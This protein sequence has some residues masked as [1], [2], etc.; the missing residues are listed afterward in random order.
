MTILHERKNRIGILRV[1]SLVCLVILLSMIGFSFANGTQQA[2]ADSNIIYVKHNASGANDGTSWADAYTSLQSAIGTAN[3]GDEIWVAQGVYKPTTGTSRQATFSLPMDVYIFGGF[4]GIETAR[5]QRDWL[6]NVTVLSGD[7]TGD[8]ITDA[9]GIIRD[10]ANILGDDNVFHVVTA[11][12]TT[13]VLDGFVVTGG[14][15]NGGEDHDHGAGLYVQSAPEENLRLSPLLRNLIV[16]GNLAA[17][18]G[19]GMYNRESNPQ[20]YNV[21]FQ[22]NV[23]AAN[24]GGMYASYSQAVLTNVD[25]RGNQA[26]QGGG[27]YNANGNPMLTNV[28]LSGNLASSSG[29][30]LFNSFGSPTLNGVTF[31]SN[32]APGSGGGIYSTGTSSSVTVVNS[33]LWD[34]TS[35]YGPEI[36]RRSGAISVSYSIVR[37][38]YAGEGNVDAD[39]LFVAPYSSYEAPTASGDYRLRYGSPAIDAGTNTD[40]PATDLD[41]LP[42]PNDGDASGT[43]TCDMGA[44]EAGT[45]VCSVGLGVHTFTNHPGVTIEVATL[46]DELGCLYVDEMGAN[47]AHATGAPGNG[48][49][50]GRYWLI[51]GLQSDK[52]TDATGFEVNLTLPHNLADH[53]KASVCRYTGST[54]DCAQTGSTTTTVWR[55]GISA[56]SDWTVGNDVPT[57]V[58]LASFTATPQ[59][60]A[61]LVTW[62]T[63]SEL[64]N[65]GFNLYRSTSPAGPWTQLNTTLIPAQNP[66]AVFGAT[67]EW[68]DTDVTPGEAVYYRLEDVDVS[69]VSTFH[70]PVSATASGVTTVRVTAFGAATNQSSLLTLTLMLTGALAITFSIWNGRRSSKLR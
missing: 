67:Y 8:D 51:R 59:N 33:I 17:G 27:I 25:F 34:N 37:S 15:A 11:I 31:G 48:T 23:A 28:A 3:W 6:T 29:G 21:T 36:E 69:G 63:A 18:N 22:S 64:D 38:G 40:C 47:H 46:G 35:G 12:T 44:Y 26:S 50:T 60:A 5:N 61:I 13:G 55:N 54:W 20:L 14:K 53:T 49:M 4:M 57:A 43:A 1:A 66:G 42:R 9:N 32:R 70:G 19:G 39:P 45:M 7:L 62:E 68:L 65:L 24:G 16:I 58:T 56:F 10:T 41:G 2:V 52:I 30:G